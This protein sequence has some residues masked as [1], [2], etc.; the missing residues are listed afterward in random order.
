[1][2]R[3]GAVALWVGSGDFIC[4]LEHLCV[5]P[6]K[7]T[8]TGDPPSMVTCAS[9]PAPVVTCTGDPSHPTPVVTCASN[10][11]SP[12]PTVVTCAGNPA[13][14]VTCTGKT[15]SHVLVSQ[16]LGRQRQEGL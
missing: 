15:W 12:P 3:V 5:K 9:N 10:P 14:V 4:I 8:C 7:V 2:N 16:S 1:M 6:A 11:H 13:P